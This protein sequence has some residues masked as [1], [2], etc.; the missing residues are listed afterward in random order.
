M[1]ESLKIC[2]ICDTTNHPNASVCSTCGTDLTDVKALARVRKA[3]ISSPKDYDFRYG[4]TDLLEESL[5][6]VAR[7]YTIMTTIVVTA[8][9]IAGFAFAWSMGLLSAE[10]DGTTIPANPFTDT[11]SPTL[12]LITVTMGPPTATYTFTPSPSFTPSITPTRGPCV[13][14][15][16]TGGT[17]TGALLNCGHRSMDV[18]QEV[19]DMNN[20]SDASQIR[21]GQQILIPWPTETPNPFATPTEAESSQGTGDEGLEVSSIELNVAI[22]AFAPTEIPSLPAGIQWHRVQPN[23]NIISIA[24]AYSANVK[25]L[26]ELNREIDFAR[27]DFGEAYGGPECIVQLFQGQLLRVP[28]PTPTPTLSPTNDPNSTATATAT[29]T[30]N[31]PSV[32]SPDDRQFFYKNQLIT[33]RWI[34]SA[35]LNE[36]E[37]YR[38]DVQDSTIGQ[39]YTALTQDISFT[40]PL[41]WQGQQ[42][43]RHDYLWT[44]GIVNQANPDAVR[45]QTAPHSFVWEGSL[46]SDN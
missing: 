13:I 25:T 39:A 42:A 37:F 9:M 24:F 31:V 20:I 6:G 15:M 16:Q 8:L 2:P 38:V 5:S 14:T 1:S 29:P 11:P 43:G 32:Y 12:Y 21:V 7:N 44:V 27:C 34:P 26:S 46:E 10:T 33:L 45:Y 28:A 41:E 17:I 35:T 23:E 18:L 4:E 36:G 40:I 30:Y 19:L 3:S 22:D